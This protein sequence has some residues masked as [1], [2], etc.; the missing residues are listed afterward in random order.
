MTYRRGCCRFAVFKKQITTDEIT[1][2]VR[3][4]ADFG[5]VTVLAMATNPS[6]QFT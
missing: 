4:M 5:A 2:T 1:R 3:Q 6:S